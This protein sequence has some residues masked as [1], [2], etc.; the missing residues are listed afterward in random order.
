MSS[1]VIF[2]KYAEKVYDKVRVGVRIT[3]SKT[4]HEDRTYY[5]V[6]RLKKFPMDSVVEGSCN[7]TSNFFEAAEIAKKDLQEMENL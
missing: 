1:V 7:F 6:H 5:T 3:M 2:E 4:L